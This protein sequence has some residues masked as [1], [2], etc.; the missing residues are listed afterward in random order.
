[1]LNTHSIHNIDKLTV[2]F[3]KQKFLMHFRN[4]VY[5]SEKF[6][7]KYAAYSILSKTHVHIM[8]L[9]E[10]KWSKISDLSDLSDFKW[11]KWI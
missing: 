7:F 4:F 11:F 2:V 9:L 6:F 3:I 1:M 5:L 8:S 10:F